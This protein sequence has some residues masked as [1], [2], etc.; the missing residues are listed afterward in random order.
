MPGCSRANP[1]GRL[2]NN[3]TFIS[4]I[5]LAKVPSRSCAF[6]LSAHARCGDR[7][8]GARRRRATTWRATTCVSMLSSPARCL[9]CRYRSPSVALRFRGSWCLGA[10]L[11]RVFFRFD[12][13]VVLAPAATSGLVIRYSLIYLD[14]FIRSAGVL[15]R[16]GEW[17]PTSTLAL[18]PICHRIMRRRSSVFIRL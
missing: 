4:P 10:S 9:A 16:C 14:L 1:R 12:E 18:L 15:A 3:C 6:T 13:N 2:P 7:L 17:L 5:A 8:I 11:C